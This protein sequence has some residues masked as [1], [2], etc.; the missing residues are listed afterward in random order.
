MAGNSSTWIRGLRTDAVDRHL[1]REREKWRVAEPFRAALE[2]RQRRRFADFREH[3]DGRSADVGIRLRLE[4]AAA[5][6]RGSFARHVSDQA[7]GENA[8]VGVRIFQ[9]RR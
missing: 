4:K 9:Q 8:D 2:N 7:T 3:L 5:E 6:A 1:D